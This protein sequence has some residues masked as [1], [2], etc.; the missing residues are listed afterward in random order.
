MK[1]SWLKKSH[2]AAF[3]NDFVVQSLRCV[4]VFATPWTT[5]CQASLSF[6]NSQSFL[7]LMSTELVMLS[8]H[9]IYCH[10]LLL[11]PSVFPSIRVFST[12]S[13]FSIR[14]PKYWS[15]SFSISP[16]DEYSWLISFRIDWLDPLAV[17]G[18]LKSLPQHYSSKASVLSTQPSLWSNSHIQTWPLEKPTLILKH[19]Y[20]LYLTIR[21]LSYSL[22]FC[23]I[24]W[25]TYSL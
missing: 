17:Q 2:G 9:L 21:P 7:K 11:L 8:N 5:A 16:S 6:T 13:A 24:K 22:M 19:D 15:F 3:W 12:E 1:W 20:W 4:Q 14:C 23:I 25:I 10:P 18:T